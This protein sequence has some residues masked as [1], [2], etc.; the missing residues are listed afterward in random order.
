MELICIQ[1]VWFSEASVTDAMWSRP[2]ILPQ[3]GELSLLTTA[4]IKKSGIN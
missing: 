2:T 1:V 3:T 4:Q